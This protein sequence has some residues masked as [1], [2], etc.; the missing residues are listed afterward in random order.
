MKGGNGGREKKSGRSLYPK[1]HLSLSHVKKVV[2]NMI[3]FG[4]EWK[5]KFFFT[6]VTSV[7]EKKENGFFRVG[8][9]I[10]LDTSRGSTN[11]KTKTKENERSNGLVE[12]W[13]SSTPFSENNHINSQASSFFLF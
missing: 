12:T 7:Y 5:E 13:S 10:K 8:L 1:I 11:V 9:R 6:F 2:E 4:N 3:D